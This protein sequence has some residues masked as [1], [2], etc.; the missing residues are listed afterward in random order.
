[1]A[2]RL[3]RDQL[4]LWHATALTDDALLVT[5][6][7]VTNAVTHGQGEVA[8]SL[9]CRRLASGARQLRIEVSDQG[10]GISRRQR[11]VTDRA[12]C[13]PALGTGGR[14]LY[15]VRELADSWGDTP[16]AG[17]HTTWAVLS[18][19]APGS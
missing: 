16:A 4:M 13:C 15:L 14:G 1:M 3:L 17:G 18:R 7:L 12:G 11:A 8:L 9:S 2:R 19:S 5:C 6:E 10:S